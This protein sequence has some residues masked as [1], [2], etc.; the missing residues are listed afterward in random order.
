E[1]FKA[2]WKKIPLTADFKLDLDAMEKAID[3]T[4]VLVYLCNPNNPTGTTLDPVQLKAFCQRVSSKIPVFIDEAYID[5]L[6]NPEEASMISLVKDGYNVMVTR[7]FSKLYGFAGLRVGYMVAPP[8]ILKLLNP[9]SIGA[10]SI[11]ATSANAAL[12]AYQDTEFLQSALK[13]TQESKEF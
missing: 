3:D 5:Y 7:T 1:F 13:G 8:E 12:A 9:Y 10:R 4:T 11:S 6:E 2:K